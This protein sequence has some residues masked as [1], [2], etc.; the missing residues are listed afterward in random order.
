MTEPTPDPPSTDAPRGPT[1]DRLAFVAAC[2][3]EATELEALHVQNAALRQQND[4]LANTLQASAYNVK[5]HMTAEMELATLRTLLETAEAALRAIGRVKISKMGGTVCAGCREMQAI[6]ELALNPPSPAPIITTTHPSNDMIPDGPGQVFVAQTPAAASGGG[7]DT[8]VRHC[9]VLISEC[10]YNC[11]IGT[12]RQVEREA[13]RG[14]GEG[15]G[16]NQ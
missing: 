7:G 12:C 8:I 6:A 11:P 14:E 2:V 3:L 5:D 10:Y 1:E 9:P 13:A 4:L 15:G 16:R